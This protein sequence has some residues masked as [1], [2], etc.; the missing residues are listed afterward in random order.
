M[1]QKLSLKKRVVIVL[2]RQPEDLDKCDALIVPG[3][4]VSASGKTYMKAN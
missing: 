3:G 1:L 2:I 4:G